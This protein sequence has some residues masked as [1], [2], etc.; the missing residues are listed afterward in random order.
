[1]KLLTVEGVKFSSLIV[2]KYSEMDGVDLYLITPTL[3]P[4]GFA[5]TSSPLTILFKKSSTA[6]QSSAPSARVWSRMI[7]T[8]KGLLPSSKKEKSE[9]ASNYKKLSFKTLNWEENNEDT[10]RPMIQ[11][12]L[13][14]RQY[15]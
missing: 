4:S 14:V 1:M 9:L 3:A 10:W 8:S 12:Y 2:L 13:A 6:L 15:S 5:E 7:P 11:A